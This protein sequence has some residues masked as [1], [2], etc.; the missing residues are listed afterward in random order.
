METYRSVIDCH[1]PKDDLI[2]TNNDY[3]Q[4][5]PDGQPDYADDT[6]ALALVGGSVTG[7]AAAGAPV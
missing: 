3:E 7:Q 1:D 5:L 2:L 6:L 4:G